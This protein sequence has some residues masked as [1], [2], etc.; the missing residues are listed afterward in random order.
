MSECKHENKEFRKLNFSS[1]NGFHKILQCIDCGQKITLPGMKGH[2][3]AKEPG[4]EN[5][6]EMDVVSYQHENARLAEEKKKKTN[7]DWRR[8]HHEYEVYINTSEEW[9]KIR[10]KVLKRSSQC[11]ACL[12]AKATQVHHMNY[13]SLFNEIAYDLRAVCKDCH[14]KIHDVRFATPQPFD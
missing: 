13:D 8:K 11:E 3:F 14:K 5:L 10:S 2:F 12:D 6:P 9:Q 7:E 4:D 1:G